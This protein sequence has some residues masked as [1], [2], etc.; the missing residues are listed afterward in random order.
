MPNNNAMTRR[1]FFAVEPDS[2]TRE[3]LSTAIYPLQVAGDQRLRWL[4]REN[5]HVTL[6]FVG[7]VAP[8][9]VD[10]LRRCLQ[11]QVQHRSFDLRLTRIEPFPSARRPVV[12]AATGAVPAAALA[13]VDDLESG[14]RTLGLPAETRPWR[15]HLTLARIRGR[16]Q[17]DT[18][19]ISIDAVF[20]VQHLVLM[21]SVESSQ[22]RSYLPIERR[23]LGHGSADSMGR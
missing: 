13:I 21:E 4:S 14:C 3:I 22:G 9:T 15:P 7:D 11:A 20:T 23:L 17:I 12:L 2:A 18:A 6:R 19:P 5:W 1:V 10:A 16:Q 8:R